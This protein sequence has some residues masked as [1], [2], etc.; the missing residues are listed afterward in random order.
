VAAKNKLFKTVRPFFFSI[1]YVLS[2]RRCAA[3]SR[4][5]VAPPARRP[6]H[7]AARPPAAALLARPRLPSTGR[8][9]ALLL[10]P[11]RRRRRAAESRG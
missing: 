11:L 2:L 7:R 6:S 8:D 5:P 3:R 9:Q 1:L 10:P 4:A